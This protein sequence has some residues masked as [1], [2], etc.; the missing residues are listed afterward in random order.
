YKKGYTSQ[1]HDKAAGQ[2]DSDAP[3][4]P[5]QVLKPLA[6]HA[7]FEIAG[8]MQRVSAWEY[9][10][11]SKS[12]VPGLFLDTDLEENDPAV[13]QITGK[14]YDGDPRHR[15]EQE[16]V[17]GVGGYSMLKVQGYNVDVYHLNES[18]AALLVVELL[19]EYGDMKEVKKRCVFTSH[20]P[21]PA[22]QDSFPLDM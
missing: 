1:K 6:K 22:A 13:R 16:M 14:L 4:E 2:V 15:L 7:D 12:E 9:P 17:L 8:K 3:L 11:K 19:R 10:A 18:H 21:V 20:T 5:E